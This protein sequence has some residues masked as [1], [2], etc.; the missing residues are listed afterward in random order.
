MFRRP[1]TLLILILLVGAAIGI[2]SL[3]FV[4]MPA[5]TTRVEKAIPSDRLPR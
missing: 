3:G 1:L 5:P 2:A 4:D